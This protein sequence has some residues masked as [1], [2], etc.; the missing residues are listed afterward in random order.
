MKFIQSKLFAALL[1]SV[2]FLL[3]T[4]FLTTQGLTPPPKAEDTEDSEHAE[5]PNTKGA[6]WSFFNPE[7]DQIVTELKS[8]RDA[9]ANK[10]KQLNE[11]AARLRAERAE[12]DEALKNI[13]RL[14]LQVD[15]DV[16]RI[17]EDEAANLKKL[18]KMY[19]SMEPAG[20]ARILRELDDVIVVKILTLMK[21]AETGLILEAM[22]RLG[23][24]ETKRAAAL[25]ENLR[26]ATTTKPPAKATP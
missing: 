21:E 12:L 25:S 3:T 9:V 26:A 17:K 2:M 8:E 7:L 14:Q 18:A 16:Y 20:A 5:K 6:S 23:E 22:A 10:D 1:G 11:L 19:T 24:T 4:A 13:K 15:R